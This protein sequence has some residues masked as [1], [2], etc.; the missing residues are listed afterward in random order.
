MKR[1]EPG[2]EY[3]W[4]IDK[5]YNAFWK[6][7]KFL[8]ANYWKYYCRLL[9]KYGLGSEY[10]DF[11]DFYYD[12]WLI[13]KN[14]VDAFKKENI[15]DKNK[16]FGYCLIGFYLRNWVNRE[17]ILK[18][19]REVNVFMRKALNENIETYITEE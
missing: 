6:Q 11:T 1:T 3:Q 10:F 12:S 18:R 19:L 15:P 16:W 14:A 8:V 9:D 17:L 13:I 7:Y 5:D 4:A 2:V